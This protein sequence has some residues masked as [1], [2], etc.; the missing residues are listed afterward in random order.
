MSQQYTQNMKLGKLIKLLQTV[1]KTYGPDVL[2]FQK[3]FAICNTEIPNRVVIQKGHLQGRRAKDKPVK[4][5]CIES[6][7]YRDYVENPDD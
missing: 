3:N 6:G 1:E 2:V 4:T 5:I 7:R